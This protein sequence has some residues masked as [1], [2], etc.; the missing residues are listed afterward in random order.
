MYRRFSVVKYAANIR[1]LP[2]LGPIFRKNEFVRAVGFYEQSYLRNLNLPLYFMVSYDGFV[3]RSW[4]I[5][6]VS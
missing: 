1:F 4:V 2:I 6:N 5:Q 3:W